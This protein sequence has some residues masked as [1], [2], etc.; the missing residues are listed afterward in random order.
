MRVCAQQNLYFVLDKCFCLKQKNAFIMDF[1][2]A[3]PRKILHL[4]THVNCMWGEGWSAG[5]ILLTSLLF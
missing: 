4:D 5:V 1:K 2:D 3:N